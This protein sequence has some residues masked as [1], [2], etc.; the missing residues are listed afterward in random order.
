MNVLIDD[1]NDWLKVNENM[2]SII[3]DVIKESLEEE[4]FLEDVEVSVTLTDNEEIREINLEHRGIDKETDVIS[5]PQIDWSDDFLAPKDYTNVA[6]ED[7]IL[8]DIVISTEKLEEQAKE[9]NHSLERELGFLVAHS[10]LHLLG[11]D[12]MEEEEERAMINKQ[13]KILGK[14]GLVR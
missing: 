10:M 5:F 9:Y 6:I 8:G 12:H 4:K 2:G 11:Y 1:T 14:L 3:G 7:I 13:E